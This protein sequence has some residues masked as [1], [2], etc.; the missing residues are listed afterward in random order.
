MTRPDL[1]FAE[2]LAWLRLSRTENVGPITF[3]KL[4]DRFGSAENALKALPDL[5]R[6]GGRAAPLVAYDL[7]L[8]KREW[9]ALEKAGVLLI[10]RGEALYPKVLAEIE[11][12]PPLITVLGNPLLLNQKS[13]A[14]IGTRN[15][16]L[17]GRKMAE[18]IA[19]TCGQTG[20]T[21]VSGLARGIDT[22]AHVAALPTGTVAVVA[23]GIDIVYP[24]ENEKL[25]RAII[26]QGAIVAESPLGMQPLA[27][28]FPKR[29]R[30]VSG[31]SLGTVVIEAAQR[32]GSLITARLALEQNRE[33]FAVPGSPLDPRSGGTNKLIKESSAHLITS[34][35]DVL[36]I[37][38]T[39]RLRPLFEPEPLAFSG[40]AELAELPESMEIKRQ[41]VQAQVLELLS[42]SPIAVDELV[43]EC[44]CSIAEVLAVLLE[45]E[46]AGR[47]ERHPGNRMSLL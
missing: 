30:I 25:Y 14:V 32:S 13:L 31:L 3:Y 5:S 44:E 16:S 39:L 10:A 26:E 6:R 21:I 41:A 11:D 37:M 40:G 9:D 19:R 23:G 27:R 33:V 22:A 24:P 42:P 2:K 47:V 46:L 43:R 17:T 8:V 1:D 12:A 35:A 38:N 7:D 29:N 28:H 34:A 36:D 4:I 20:Y 18:E 15:A 45:L